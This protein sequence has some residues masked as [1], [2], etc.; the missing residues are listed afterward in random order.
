MSRTLE[1]RWSWMRSLHSAEARSFRL[2]VICAMFVSTLVVPLRTS[3]EEAAEPVVSGDSKGTAPVPLDVVVRL[4]VPWK[5]EGSLSELE[6]KDQRAAIQ[7]AQNLLVA[8]MEGMKP[9]RVIHFTHVPYTTMTV[10]QRDIATL[11]SL[12]EVATVARAKTAAFSLD[13]TVH[14]LEA[15]AVW[16]FGYTGAGQVVAVLDTGVWGAHDLLTGKLREEACFSLQDQYFESTCPSGPTVPHEEGPGAA[17]P[18]CLSNPNHSSGPCSHGTHVASIAAGHTGVAKGSEIIAANISA[19]HLDNPTTPED[20]SGLQA[21]TV[22]LALALEWVNDLQMNVYANDPAHYIAAVNLSLGF[23]Q[24]GFQTICDSAPDYQV[25][26]DEITNLH[27]LNIATIAATGNTDDHE[28][29]PLGTDVPACFSNV[30]SVA[31]STKDDQWWSVGGLPVQSHVADFVDLLA[32]G[33]DIVSATVTGI[34]DTDSFGATSGATPQV[35]GAVALLREQGPT[36]GVESLRDA[37]RFTG[38]P[39]SV[40]VAGVGELPRVRIG[41]ALSRDLPGYRGPIG[42]V[43]SPRCGGV[44]ETSSI[45]LEGW[46][47]DADAVETQVFSLDGS[48]VPG[49]FQA[50]YADATT[51]SCGGSP[52]CPGVGENLYW[53]GDLDLSGSSNATHSLSVEAV[54]H[55]GNTEGYDWQ[56][57]LENDDPELAVTKPLDGS[58]IQCTT[59]VIEGW[60]TDY[61]SSIEG[62]TYSFDGKASRP[63]QYGVS[64]P[65]APGCAE[66][67]APDPRCES[68]RVWFRPFPPRIQWCCDDFHNLPGQCDCDNWDEQLCADIMDPGPHTLVI[69][70]TDKAG[71]TTHSQTIHITTVN[72]A[73]NTISVESPNGGEEW[74]IGSPETISWTSEGTIEHVTIELSRNGGITYDE[75]PLAEWVPNVGSYLWT[76]TGPPT[77]YAVIRVRDAENPQTSDVSNDV[78]EISPASTCQAGPTTLC[79]LDDRFAASVEWYNPDSGSSGTGQAIE[80]SDQGG[81]FWFFGP[82]N[83]EVG[84]KV[85]DGRAINGFYWVFHGSLTSVQYTLT[86]T[87]TQNGTVNTYVKPA[88]GP[89]A[90]ELCGEGDTSAFGGSKSASRDGGASHGSMSSIEARADEH[91]PT[92]FSTTCTQ[93]NHHLCLLNDRYR[94]EVRRG[95]EPQGAAA[96]TSDSG[97]FWFFNPYNPEVIIKV[98]DGAAI[99]GMVWVFYGAMTDLDFEVEVADTETGQTKIYSNP[100]PYCGEADIEAFDP[101][102]SPR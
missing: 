64:G 45:H 37:L 53:D 6:L 15:D 81:F 58:E 4:K 85:L 32:P 51:I 11:L 30:I 26:F 73:A 86:V 50:S 91:D 60:A 93:D 12:P 13:E 19:W 54:D 8:Q 56:F 75:P 68:G 83:V 23:G 87:D 49:G 94:V 65:P 42:S 80:Y 27:S 52:L 25:L 71:R 29:D 39:I 57:T 88:T 5:P 16:D 79:F 2:V 95:G 70:A 67:P 78:F 61:P 98:L 101:S 72:P 69:E 9:A 18:P 77:E 24:G 17:L 76:V 28:P 84:V 96:I 20:E 66:P 35:T 22:T 31:A 62:V 34:H 90:T 41:A 99:N 46:A 55:V 47:A 3:G 82:E 38:K 59:I 1:R 102:Q 10:T 43:Q 89:G 44:F 36:L 97:A 40:P 100:H 33:D 63:L 21:T 7:T 14:L 92:A 74:P 48:P